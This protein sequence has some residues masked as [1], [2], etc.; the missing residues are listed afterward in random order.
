MNWGVLYIIRNWLKYTCFKWACMTHLNIWNT[1]YGQKKGW[2][3][4]CQFDFQPKKV[5]NRPD[6]LT[7][8]WHATYYWRVLDQGLNFSLYL[9]SIVGLH[10]KLWGPKDEGVPTLAISRLPFGSG[11]PRTKCLLDVGFVE[12]HKVYYKGEGG[13]FPQVQAVVNLMNP[14]LP[15]V[16][17]STKSVQTMH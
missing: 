6:F 5:E 10:A 14:S 12:R 9:I 17:F 11:S 2:G 1:S 16:H 13:G 15:V 3:S 7:C 8:K 4:N